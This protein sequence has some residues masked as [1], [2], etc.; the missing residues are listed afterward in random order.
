MTKKNFS[1][2]DAVWAVIQNL[3]DSDRDRATNRALIAEQFNG[4]PPWSSA[5]AQENNIETNVNF[6]EGPKVALD[7]RGQFYN[8]FLKPSN[9][10][11]VEIDMDD[12]TWAL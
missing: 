3:K 6:L 7:A 2:V 1:Q 8:A 4:E 5:E 9:F 11:T 12:E 10:F